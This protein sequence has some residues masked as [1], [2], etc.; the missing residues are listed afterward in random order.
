MTKSVADALLDFRRENALHIDEQNRAVWMAQLGSF[1]FPLPNFEW[2]RMVINH[3][4]V[5]HILTG[6]STSASGELALASWELGARCFKGRR[7]G[8][9]CAFLM[10]LGALS[11]PRLT[12]KAYRDGK[13]QAAAYNALRDQS[14][15]DRPLRDVKTALLRG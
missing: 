6:Y 13:R 3:H 15:F 11:Q 12:R 1:I 14:F 2:R 5:H 4:D 10:T 9:L 7:A 8:L